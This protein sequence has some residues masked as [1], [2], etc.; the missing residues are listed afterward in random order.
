VT[1]WYGDQAGQ[2]VLPQMFE[3][4][5]RAWATGEF[6]R[7][8][9]FRASDPGGPTFLPADEKPASTDDRALAGGALQPADESSPPGS[10]RAGASEIRIDLS[11][12]GVGD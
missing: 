2:Q 5:V 12:I 7:I 8:Y 10:D 11:R 1:R 6:E 9:V 3:D 4:A